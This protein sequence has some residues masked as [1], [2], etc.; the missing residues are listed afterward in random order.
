MALAYAPQL[1]AELQE[2]APDNFAQLPRHLL[3]TEHPGFVASRL[4]VGLMAAA[5]LEFGMTP[6][7]NL[8][9]LDR[10]GNSGIVGKGIYRPPLNLFER[11]INLE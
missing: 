1:A 11:A 6:L 3:A 5:T 2:I 8:A 4:R 10:E 7:V 9:I